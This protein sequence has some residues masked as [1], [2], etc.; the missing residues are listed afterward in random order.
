MTETPSSAP[1]FTVAGTTFRCWIIPAGKNEA[2][3]DGIK[4]VWVSDDL[5]LSCGKAPARFEE[6]VNEDG[7]A[8]FRAI[9]QYWAAI[10]RV[11]VGQ[12]YPSLKK[13][14]IEATLA[15][16]RKGQRAA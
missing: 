1:P 11:Y 7:E 4:Y 10:D 5:R 13:A 12:N 3:V 2:G 6:Y 9:P 14:L 15:L 16:Q 8:A